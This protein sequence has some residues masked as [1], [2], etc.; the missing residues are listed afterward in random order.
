MGHLAYN[1]KFF[2]IKKKKFITFAQLRACLILNAENVISH[3]VFPIL[4]RR[5]APL[6][7]SANATYFDGLIWRAACGHCGLMWA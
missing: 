2:Y 3:W 1:I 7:F 6:L 4:A 5:V